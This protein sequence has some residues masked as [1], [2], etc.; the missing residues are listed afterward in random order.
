MPLVVDSA[1]SL[2]VDAILAFVPALVVG[3]TTAV[4]ES[5][6]LV[7][8]ITIEGGD[9]VCFIAVAVSLVLAFGL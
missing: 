1:E 2:A 5:L 7:S 6:V 3:I 4:S 8:A 9:D